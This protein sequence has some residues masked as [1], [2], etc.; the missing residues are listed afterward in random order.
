MSGLRGK[1]KAQK[2]E[3]PAWKLALETEDTVSSSTN[4]KRPRGEETM[5]REAKSLGQTESPR[6]A[7]APASSSKGGAEVDD[8]DDDDDDVD[9]SAYDLGDGKD[10]DEGGNA[11]VEVR[12][13]PTAEELLLMR[14][15]RDTAGKSTRTYFVDDALRSHEKSAGAERKK[16]AMA[17]R[18]FVK[19]MSHSGSVSRVGGG[20]DAQDVLD[21]AARSICGGSGSSSSYSGREDRRGR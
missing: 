6:K 5:D 21:Q 14:E 1:G 10:D 18:A 2:K 16:D 3:V 9:L 17:A 7:P 4:N 8:D 15:A 13:M 20:F 11:Q 12:H 19:T